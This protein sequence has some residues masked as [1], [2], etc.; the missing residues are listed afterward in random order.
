MRPEVTLPF[1]GPSALT[2]KNSSEV[3]MNELIERSEHKHLVR[4]MSG[5][6]TWLPT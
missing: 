5:N 4:G 6:G 1:D 2:P 3:N